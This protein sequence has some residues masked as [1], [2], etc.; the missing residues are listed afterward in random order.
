[1]RSHFCSVLAL[2][3]ALAVQPAAAQSPEEM[4]ESMNASMAQA[5][6]Q[7]SRPGDE[8]LTC[9]QL[10]TEMV[11]TMQDPAVQSAIAANGADAQQ[12]LDQMN[13]ATGRA[14]AQIGVSLFMGI[15]SAFIPGMGYAQMAAQQA[16]AVQQQRQAQQN[17][18]QIMQ[19]SERMSA[20]MPNIMRGQRVYQLAQAQQCPFLDEQPSAPPQ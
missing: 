17:M 7:A 19:M 9:D 8:A 20:I 16:M 2:S 6:A 14:Q 4:Y 13:A 1:M 3:L 12:Q 11:T 18:A 5:E 15:A 10:Q